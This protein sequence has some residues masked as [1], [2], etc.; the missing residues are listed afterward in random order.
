MHALYYT[1]YIKCFAN[2]VYCSVLLGFEP[3][4]LVCRASS[5]PIKPSGPAQLLET[6]NRFI[7]STFDYFNCS[8]AW[9]KSHFQQCHRRFQQPCCRFT[10]KCWISKFYTHRTSLQI[11]LSII[12]TFQSVNQKVIFNC[13]LHNGSRHLKTYQNA[14]SAN[15]QA[16]LINPTVNYS[17]FSI[18]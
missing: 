7:N 17:D 9:L 1:H 13:T 4:S 2:W 14:N 10:K 15:S 6:Q 3:S 8:I 11:W 5:L 12:L 16:K 18:A